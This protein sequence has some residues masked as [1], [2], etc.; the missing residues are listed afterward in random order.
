MSQSR[1]SFRNPF[2][3]EMLRGAEGWESMYPSYLQFGEEL[4]SGT[5][6]SSGSSTRCTTRS[7]STPSTS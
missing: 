1:R 7:R 5:S 6:R 3:I 4:R 2:D